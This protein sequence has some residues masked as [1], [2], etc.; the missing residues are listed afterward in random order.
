MSFNLR[1]ARVNEGLT[2]RELAAEVGVSLTVVQRL[3]NGGVAH[4]ANAK[5]VAD[6]FEVEV[7]DLMTIA[8]RDAA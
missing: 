3:E 8:R 5:K 1:E 2:Q 4:P 7:R 6:R